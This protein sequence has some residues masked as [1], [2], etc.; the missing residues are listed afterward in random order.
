AMPGPVWW[1]QQ[2]VAP[3]D[4]VALW[5]ACEQ[6]AQQVYAT[7]PSLLDQLIAA[8]LARRLAQPDSMAALQW[9]AAHD[10]LMALHQRFAQSRCVF[11][12]PNVANEFLQNR[13]NAGERYAI[14]SLLEL[15]PEC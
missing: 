9:Q 4:P 12:D 6:F 2:C 11:D 10:E 14:E 3:S 1:V 5:A 15:E 8:G 7:A 13:I